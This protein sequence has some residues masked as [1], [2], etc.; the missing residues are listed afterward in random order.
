MS[1]GLHFIL[2]QLPHAAKCRLAQTLGLTTK[3]LV[4]H[5][6]PMKLLPSKPVRFALLAIALL[7][8]FWGYCYEFAYFARLRL[9]VHEHLELRH[10]VVSSASSIIPMLVVLVIYG[11]V[12][13]LFSKGI[14]ADPAKE[15]VEHLKTASFDQFV[16][17]AR[18]GAALAAIFLVAVIALPAL[19]INFM[20]WHLYLYMVFVVL[21]S[22]FGAV[23]TSPA[24]ARFP[25]LLTLALSIAACYA[26]GGYGH[27]GSPVSPSSGVLRDDLVV[28]V[29][30]APED[31]ILV[32]ARPLK[33]TLPRPLQFLRTLWQ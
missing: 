12:K 7:L 13:R 6:L 24:H 11:N 29:A 18:A 33:I 3:P 8:G 16:P 27:A 31:R 10:F 28:K 15:V 25:V 20:I 23:F 2:A 4:E 9:N 30:K 1:I 14:H 17:F 32:E 5:P 22:F 21:Q 26:G 19:G